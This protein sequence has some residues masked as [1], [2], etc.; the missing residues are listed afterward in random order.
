MGRNVT[1][2][3]VG[4]NVFIVESTESTDAPSNRST[5]DAYRRH[6]QAKEERIRSKGLRSGVCSIH[7]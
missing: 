4:K 5:D 1:V 7:T 6:E 3:I 2:F